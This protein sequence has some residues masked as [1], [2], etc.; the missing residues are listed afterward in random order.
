MYNFLV[1][2]SNPYYR[3]HFDCNLY[4]RYTPTNELYAYTRKINLMEALAQTDGEVLDVTQF[5]DEDI[6]CHAIRNNEGGVTI[7]LSN[8][9]FKETKKVRLEFIDISTSAK[10]RIGVM[11]TSNEDFI[12]K[13]DLQITGNNAEL[14][15]L[16]LS[17]SKIDIPAYS[18]ETLFQSW[19][20]VRSEYKKFV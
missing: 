7:F 4:I 14:K 3:E 20:D 18:G 19:I 15:L 17:I 12:P 10:V 5:K 11:T 13:H 16:P 2:T 9:N 6:T 8:K 1:R